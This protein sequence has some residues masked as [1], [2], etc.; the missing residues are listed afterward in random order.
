MIR[1]FYKDAAF[2]G[3]TEVLIRLKGLVVLPLLTHHFGAVSFGAWSQVLVLVALVGPFIVLGSDSGFM[4][5]AA[6]RDLET[7]K[8]CFSAWVLFL[9]G[10]AVLVCGALALLPEAI[11]EVFFGEPAEYAPLIFLAAASLF[12]TALLNAARNWF[13]LQFRPRLY[14]VISVLQAAFGVLAVVAVLVLDQGVFELVVYTLIGDSAI[15]LALYG[16]IGRTYG[17]ARPDFSVLGPALKFGL[18][19][20]PAGFAMWGLNMMD[21][22]FLVDYTTLAEVGVY[23][24][25]YTLGY[26]V[27]TLLARPYR[28][29]YPTMATTFYNQRKTAELQRI[30]NYSAGTVLALT[31]PAMVGLFVLRNPI[32]ALLAP[33]EFS[34]GAPLM[35]LVTM[36]YILMIMASYYEVHLGLVFRQ[37]WISVSVLVACAANFVLNMLLIPR[38]GMFGA[39]VATTASFAIQ[40]VISFA[41]AQRHAVVKSD[42]VFAVKVVAASLLM[43][44]VVSAA[45]PVIFPGA[46]SLYWEVA[47]MSLIGAVTFVAVMLAL[48]AL[49]RDKLRLA[50]DE[51]AVRFTGG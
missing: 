3:V 11:T 34:A 35:A 42:G 16:F 12:L 2:V 46:Q 49:P 50:Y 19:L 28:M 48:G 37:H 22:L 25:V 17:L 24:L 18:P 14:A 13:L 39:A 23:S 7:Q 44:G 38:Y 9:L 40:F 15:A 26:M 41:V 6:G 32:L 8:R 43:G 51:I 45:R 36:G 27:I 33:P 30:F 21:R 10:N 1:K 4:R 29:M 31:V 47:L 20:V 5:H